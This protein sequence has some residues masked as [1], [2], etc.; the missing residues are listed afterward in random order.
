MYIMKNAKRSAEKW[1][2]NRKIGAVDAYNEG[3][4]SEN[5]IKGVLGYVPEKN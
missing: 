4:V 1:N 3:R 2:R 5:W